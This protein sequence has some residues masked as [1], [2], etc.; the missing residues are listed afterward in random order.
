MLSININQLAGTSDL[1]LQARLDRIRRLAV[2]NR[3]ASLRPDK[4]IYRPRGY[5][6][7]QY[8]YLQG[9]E[10]DKLS[11]FLTR[12]LSVIIIKRCSPRRQ[13]ILINAR[14][15]AWPLQRRLSQIS[16]RPFNLRM[17]LSI[18]ASFIALSAAAVLATSEVVYAEELLIDRWQ[19]HI[20]DA[21]RRF[22]IPE[23]WIRGVMSAES[24]GRTMHAG[25]PITSPAG[26][27]GLMQLMPATYEEMRVAHGLGPDPHTPHDNILA[28]TAYL[29]VML[30]RFGYPGL[31]AAY[32]A[33]PGRYQ[34][35]LRDGKPLPKE[36][37]AYVEKLT[38]ILSS[39]RQS[40]A[41]SI[42]AVSVD[43]E[44]FFPPQATR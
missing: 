1:A 10:S 16:F 3:Y 24:S 39:P 43:G 27:V 31:F 34:A 12:N 19:L 7:W 29:R 15:L 13:C 18:N 21:S 36:T 28:G 4:M 32:N 33:G 11:S 44:I 8:N 9:E 38:R 17:M 40:R 22:D 6:C 41:V 30:E 20:A 2:R 37:R 25:R 42:D 14:Q 26:A 35:H 23:T 5:L